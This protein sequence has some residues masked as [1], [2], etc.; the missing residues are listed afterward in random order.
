M[1]G[2]KSHFQPRLTNLPE[3]WLQ[4]QAN[5]SNMCRVLR[6]GEE[7]AHVG[8]SQARKRVVRAPAFSV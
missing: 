5:G 3:K 4:C 7:E 6:L 8:L 1:L 2:L